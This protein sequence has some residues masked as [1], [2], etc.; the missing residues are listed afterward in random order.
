M[1]NVGVSGGGF[2]FEVMSVGGRWRWKVTAN[3]VIGAGQMFYVSDIQTPF[4]RL[5]EVDTPIPGVVVSSMADSLSQFQQQ[6]TPLLQVIGSSTISST[7]TEGDPITDIGIASFT[8]AGAFGSFMSVTASP[9]SPWISSIPSHIPGIGKNQIRQTSVRVNPG[10]MLSSAS[11]YSGIV[12]LQDD[13]GNVVSISIGVTVLPKPFISVNLSTIIFTFDL[14][15]QVPSGTQT[16]IVTNSGPATS[17]L[18][19]SLSKIQNTSP[20]LV[21]SPSSGGPISSLDSSSFGLSLLTSSVPRIAGTYTDTIRV[22]SLNASNSP[23]NIS[24]QLVVS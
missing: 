22:S 5:Y 9:D 23:V 6:L 8:N 7:V 24:V 13:R 12:S 10:I 18:K 16:V 1:A 3:N 4:G 14:V 15:T 11:P 21:F 17:I 19:Y 20:W 2:E